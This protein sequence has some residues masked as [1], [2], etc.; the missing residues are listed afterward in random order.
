MKFCTK[1]GTQCEDTA[2]CCH[3]CGNRFA[4]AAPA[5][6]AA[7]VAPVP[8]VDPHD[9]TGEM[10]KGD[11]SSNK[12][13]AVT[14]SLLPAMPFLFFYLDQI[15]VL[16][17]SHLD[18]LG[19]FLG[20]YGSPRNF[21]T[22]TITVIIALAVLLIISKDSKFAAFHI[23]QALKVS[24]LN[25]PIAFLSVIP[26]IGWPVAFCAALFIAILAVIQF[27]NACGGKAKDLPLVGTAKFLN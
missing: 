6:N 20:N 22:V 25:L 13:F 16:F 21:V 3:K 17:S 8:Y 19:A 4:D 26:F 1:C 18:W 5:A 12:I 7:P 11:I 2:N 14:A 15:K 23:K 10:E 24:I 9:H 27:F